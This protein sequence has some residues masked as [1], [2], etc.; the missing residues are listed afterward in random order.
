MLPSSL[1]AIF[2]TEPSALRHR[3]AVAPAG[4]VGTAGFTL[5]PGRNVL[6]DLC[7][8]GLDLG[9]LLE[10]ALAIG[11][12]TAKPLADE[13]A[14]AI[15]AVDQEAVAADRHRLGIRIGAGADRAGWSGYHNPI[16]Q[17]DI[18]HTAGGLWIVWL[19]ASVEVIPTADAT[20][21]RWSATVSERRTLGIGPTAGEA[22]L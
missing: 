6:S 11:A 16:P 18:Q 10:L 22:C 1:P 15:L 9:A 19:T 21:A 13:W 7:Q 20:E 12:A 14:L 8:R 3:S 2:A 5:G 17:W 4:N